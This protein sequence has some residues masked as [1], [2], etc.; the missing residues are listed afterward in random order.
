[1]NHSFPPDIQE[2]LAWRLKSGGYASEEEVI[3]DAMDALEQ[4]DLDV[5]TRWNERNQLAE[6]QSNHGLCRASND[7][8][9]LGRLRARLAAEG[10]FD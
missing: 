5:V 1:M 6:S 7:E 10:I 2:R 9:V 8:E 4:R 3:R